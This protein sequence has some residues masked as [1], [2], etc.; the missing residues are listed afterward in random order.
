MKKRKSQRISCSLCSRGF[1]DKSIRYLVVHRRCLHASK[2]RKNAHYATRT[3]KTATRCK[4][5]R[6]RTHTRRVK[7]TKTILHFPLCGRC[8]NSIRLKDDPTLDPFTHQNIVAVQ[9][10]T[11]LENP[12]KLRSWA[13]GTVLKRPGELV[14]DKAWDR[15]PCPRCRR[16]K[17]MQARVCS[18]CRRPDSPRTRKNT[19]LNSRMPRTMLRYIDLKKKYNCGFVNPKRNK[20]LNGP[21]VSLPK[22]ALEEAFSWPNQKNEVWCPTPMPY[23]FNESLLNDIVGKRLEL[24]NRENIRVQV[25]SVTSPGTESLKNGD[26]GYII[27]KCRAVNNY[28]ANAIRN[29]T[30]RFKV[31]ACLPMRSPKAAAADLERCVRELGFVGALVNGYDDCGKKKPL[32]YDTKNYD[33]LWQ[34]FVELDVPLYLHPRVFLSNGSRFESTDTLYF[35]NRYPEL[36]ESAWGFHDR[37][38]MQVLRMLISGLFERNPKFKLVLGHAGEILPW[39]AERFEHRLCRETYDYFDAPEAL[40]KKYNP[41]YPKVINKFRIKTKGW[42]PR[43]DRKYFLLSSYIKRNIYITTSGF[44]SDSV[45]KYLIDQY[46]EDRILFAVDYPYENQ[47]QA[48]KW[49]DSVDIKKSTKKKIAYQNAQKLLKFHI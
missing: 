34:K 5:H 16:K 17:L 23:T 38:A 45:L 10:H 47:C 11:D 22:I 33:V 9:L 24:M 26:N 20:R 25:L 39:W 19:Q 35:Y 13:N 29:H 14:Y 36:H 6:G 8:A 30:D 48:S 21:K 18:H 4:A 43:I 44:F 40:K 42:I 49:L 1:S 28:I 27:R 3:G 12:H 2:C 41:H 32:Y 31:F 37:L 46:G 7:T 15:I